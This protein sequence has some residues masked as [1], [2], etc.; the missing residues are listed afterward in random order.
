MC[1]TK[2][3]GLTTEQTHPLLRGEPKDNQNLRLVCNYKPQEG[4]DWPTERQ[5]QHDFD[6]V[7]DQWAWPLRLSA[8]IHLLSV[9]LDSAVLNG[10]LSAFGPGH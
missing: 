2:N 8:S 5:S 3:H 6:F 9:F 7:Q 4:P 1:K 10:M